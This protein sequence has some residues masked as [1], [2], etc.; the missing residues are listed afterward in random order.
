MN[1]MTKVK[2]YERLEATLFF[3]SFIQSLAWSL[4][5][6]TAIN[7]H[8]II[9]MLSL[10]ETAIDVYFLLSSERIFWLGVV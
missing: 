9:L 6:F 10:L 7:W 3:H 8:G 2:I 4:V 5:G 1:K